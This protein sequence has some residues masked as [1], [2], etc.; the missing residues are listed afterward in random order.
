[1]NNSITMETKL[2]VREIMI[3]VHTDERTVAHRLTYLPSSPMTYSAVKEAVQKEFQIKGLLARLSELGDTDT[4]RGGRAI[5]AV[6][7]L[8][9]AYCKAIN[10]AK[11][12]DT[13]PVL[14]SCLDQ[15]PLETLTQIVAQIARD[16]SEA[17]LSMISPEDKE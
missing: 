17:F 4:E 8:G 9:E 14:I 15:I 16:C 10:V 2:D 12:E 5:V 3:N 6:S 13:S 11:Y 1:M 7:E